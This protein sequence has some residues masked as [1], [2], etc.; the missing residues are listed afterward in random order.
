M[1][2]TPSMIEGQGFITPGMGANNSITGEPCD[3]RFDHD[4]SVM[5]PCRKWPPH[6]FPV[7]MALEGM[8]E[9]GDAGRIFEARK[10]M[11]S[12]GHPED[13]RRQGR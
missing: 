7:L 8:S 5:V 12:S 1:V 13:T 10:G 9:N 2:I 3:E 11:G 4:R 6:L